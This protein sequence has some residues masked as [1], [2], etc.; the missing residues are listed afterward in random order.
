M[1]PGPTVVPSRIVRAM[2][3]PILPHRGSAF[4]KLF[5]EQAERLKSVFRTESDV[6]ILCGSG[7]AAMEAA[8]SNVVEPG[9]KVLCLV[10]GKFSERFFEIV[11]N[12][13]ADPIVIEF[14]WGN[15]VDVETVKEALAKYPD[16]KAVTMVFNETSTGVRNPVKEVGELVKGTDA[17]FVVDTISAL[18]GDEFRTDDWHVD[19]CA[20]GSQKCF[21]L[22]PGLAFISVSEKAWKVIEAAKGSSYYLNLQRYRD[23]KS[24]APY[25]PPVTLV[26]GLKEA[27]DIIDE[28]GLDRRIERHQR[29]ARIV[30]EEA[31]KMG[32]SL[33]PASEEICSSTVTAL[34]VPKGIDPA[35]LRSV[36]RDEFDIVIAGGQAQLKGDIIRIGHMGVIGEKEVYA[37]LA[38][39]SIALDRISL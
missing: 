35:R 39:L 24:H 12:F 38:C 27:L 20:T 13:K 7:T 37:T 8:I 36:L 3:A 34:R 22:P 5:L 30:R 2:S 26:Y 14:A 9:D 11:S 6:F 33:F 4:S 1:I 25:T 16:V 15:A 10:N 32:L 28:E 23:D 19:L 29:L 18:A 21:A 17:V 31:M